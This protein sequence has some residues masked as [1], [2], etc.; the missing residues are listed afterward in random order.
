LYGG[1]VTLTETAALSAVVAI[2]L[3]LYVYKGVKLSDFFHFGLFDPK[4]SGYYDYYHD[5]A[6]LWPFDY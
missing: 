3:A 5:G 2:V 4:R 1:V 6:C